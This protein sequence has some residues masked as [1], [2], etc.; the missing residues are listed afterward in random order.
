MSAD[1]QAVLG[2]AV[3]KQM[4]VNLREGLLTALMRQPSREALTP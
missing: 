1:P 4:E 2:P 3:K